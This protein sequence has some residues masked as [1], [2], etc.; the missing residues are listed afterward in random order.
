[1]VMTVNDM[2]NS[3]RRPVVI[4]H[5]GASF[6]HRENTME[7]FEAAVDMRAEMVELDV[8][9]TKDGV[10]VVHHDPHF[11]G[12][13]IRAMDRDQIEDA[14]KSSGYDI[15]TLVEV[16]QFCKDTIPVDIEL[17]EPGYEEQVI[18]TVLD[19]L[20]PDQFLIS[21]SYDMVVLKVKTLRPEIKTGL[22]LYR[23]PFLGLLRHLFPAARVRLAG[24][25]F[26]MVSQKLLGMGFLRFNKGLGK[27]VWVYTV[28]D[29]KRLWKLMADERIGG[30]FTDRPDVGLFLRDLH[31]LSQNPE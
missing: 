19:I 9:R 15:P 2:I 7:A 1:M 16:L 24:V 17:K 6:Y 28:N 20:G 3:S 26:V 11:P 29:R 30:V 21:S 4:A 5:R 22:V 14:S 23:P 12:G 18:E 10:L 31:I 27:L 13:D 25:D 8:R